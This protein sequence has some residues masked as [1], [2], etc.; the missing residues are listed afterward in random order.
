M[1]IIKSDDFAGLAA[2]VSPGGRTLNH[3]LGGS[4]SETWTSVSMTGSAGGGKFEPA[5][6]GGYASMVY[7]GNG[8]ARWKFNYSASTNIFA[9]GRSANAGGG[10]SSFGALLVGTTSLRIREHNSSGS[11]LGDVAT[12]T[13][14]AISTAT[15]YYI[16][17]EFNGTTVQARIFEADGV[18]QRG[19]TA[20]Y[21]P[22]TYPTGD[23]WGVSEYFGGLTFTVDDFTL[24]DLGG[25]GGGGPFPFKKKSVDG[26]GMQ[27]LGGMGIR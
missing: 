27:N 20:S 14:S 3:A 8:K 6:T 15:D 16:E 13:I 5:T 2:T 11:S 17:I 21:T 9:W 24:D 7:S 18:T 1:S 25:G 19:S 10:H 22:G 4:G 12:V 26:G 23:R